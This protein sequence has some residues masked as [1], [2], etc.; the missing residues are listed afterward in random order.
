MQSSLPVLR[1]GRDDV[2]GRGGPQEEVRV[3][4]L[5]FGLLV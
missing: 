2:V 1:F 3:G 5:P 4:M